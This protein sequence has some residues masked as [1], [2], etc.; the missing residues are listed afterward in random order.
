[1]STIC[2]DKMTV[3]DD[4]ELAPKMKKMKLSGSQIQGGEMFNREK[5]IKPPQ[6]HLKLVFPNISEEVI[7]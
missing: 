2:L 7:S 5:V 6:E 3:E 4:I 1:M